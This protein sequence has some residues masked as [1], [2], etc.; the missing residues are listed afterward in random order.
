MKVKVDI[1]PWGKIEADHHLKQMEEDAAQ[2][3]KKRMEDYVPMDTGALAKS[4]VVS[5][6]QISYSTP[7]ARRWY[8]QPAHFKGAPRR[9][10]HWFER[11]KNEGGA[12]AISKAVAQ[13]HGLKG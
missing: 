2:E 1:N 12:D 11:M 13:K 9:G 3:A 6:N 4:A 10:N 7:Y 8:Y 5:G